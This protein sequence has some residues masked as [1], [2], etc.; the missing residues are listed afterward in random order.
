MIRINHADKPSIRRGISPK[1]DPPLMRYSM[2]PGLK[3]LNA[4]KLVDRA[5]IKT[6]ITLITGLTLAGT[7]GIANIPEK[8]SKAAVFRRKPINSLPS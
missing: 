3:P 2:P 8:N 1:N 6:R 5:I 7:N 4:K